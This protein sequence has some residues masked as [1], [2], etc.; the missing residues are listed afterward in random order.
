MAV[1]TTGTG[2][3]AEG[4]AVRRS[5]QPTAA[6][7]LVG[8]LALTTCGIPAAAVTG[9]TAV[10]EDAAFAV[11]LTVAETR[12]CTGALVAPQWVLTA[13]SCFAAEGGAVAAG[14]PVQE[15]TATVGRTDLTTTTGHQLQVTQVVPHPDRDVAL[16]RLA[17]R[18]TDVVPVRVATE[19]PVVGDDLRVLG[20]GRTETQWV[21]DRLQAAGFTVAAVAATT[22]SI[23]TDTGATTCQ[24][25][26]GGPALHD[27]G[28][29]AALVAVHSSSGQGGCLGATG[30]RTE[31][32]ETRV[33]DL[34]GWITSTTR[35]LPAT[36]LD[37][38]GRADLLWSD[39]PGDALWWARNTTPVGGTPSLAAP[40]RLATGWAEVRDRVLADLDG[41]GRTDVLGRVGDQVRLWRV[42]GSPGAPALATPVAVGT[43][44]SDLRQL[45]P[46]DLDGD[47]RADVL[48]LGAGDALWWARNTT[49]AGGT[50]S[51]AAPARL[52][53]GW[54][55]VRDLTATD[56]DGDGRADVLGRVGTRIQLRRSTGTPG[57]PT[58]AAATPL[59][60]DGVATGGFAVADLDGDGRVDLLGIN[61][62]GRTLSWVRNTT[63]PG[64]APTVA[65]QVALPTGWNRVRELLLADLDGDGRADVLGRVGTRIQL[66]R[67]TGTPGAPT[68]AAATAL[69]IDSA[70][71]GGFLAARQGIRLVDSDEIVA[72]YRYDGSLTGIWTF[73]NIAGTVRTANPWSSG[74]GNWDAARSTP[75]TGD[76]DGDGDEELAAFYTYDNAQTKLWLF[77]NTNS[78]P[79]TRVVWDSGTGNWE[80]ARGQ[81]LA[82]DLDGD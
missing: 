10:T 23:A 39:R 33:D 60:G 62:S 67:S 29:G 50:P 2:S 6:A 34:G 21:P 4:G 56:L 18:V 16:V 9:G 80:W 69:G 59:G 65:T 20:Y 63:A 78:T 26:A 82:G 42:T 53:T 3:R 37:G 17:V 28:D 57:A 52:V 15:T 76:F 24:G 45:T 68:L 61:H 31:A 44:W 38:D 74:A 8:I 58:L 43:G 66:R 77:D 41:D 79:T 35:D 54:T 51:L 25:D 27:D 7:L 47:G 36:D 1:V 64:A 48:G 75:L 70:G 72:M 40:A 81:Y 11:R 55:G 19:S 46:G 71:V 73:D 14:P 5:R 32:V 13:R 12:A 22:L 30:T 49:P